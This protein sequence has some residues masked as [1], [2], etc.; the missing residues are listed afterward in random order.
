MEKE[1]PTE[2]QKIVSK[3]KIRVNFEVTVELR[4]AFKAKTASQG[5]Q[6]KEVLI[7]FMEDYVK[8]ANSN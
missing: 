2:T 1:I 3:K 4:N 6:V 8:D 5:K 7:A